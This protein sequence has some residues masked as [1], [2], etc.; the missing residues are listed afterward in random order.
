[1][2]SAASALCLALIAPAAAAGQPAGRLREVRFTGPSAM[3]AL[4][5]G[6][7]DARRSAE[8]Q[9]GLDFTAQ[10]EFAGTGTPVDVV[11]RVWMGLPHVIRRIHF[12][13]HSGINDSTLRRAI[14]VYERDLLDVGELR[15]SLARI[16]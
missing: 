12:A 2:K 5:A 11:A 3:D 1:M 14:T 16:N 15:R 7:L 10:A 6:L 4:C 8:A 9:G 13:G